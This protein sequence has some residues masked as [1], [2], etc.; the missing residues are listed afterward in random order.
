MK[1][2]DIEYVVGSDNVYKDLGFSDNEERLAKA[3]LAMRINE[4]IEKRGLKQIEAVKTLKINQPK[5]SAL[6]NGRLSGF[7]IEPI[8]HH[9][10][11]KTTGPYL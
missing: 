2:H 4:I 6:A 8:I 7:S 11:F 5:V 3:K 10:F 9:H 1:R